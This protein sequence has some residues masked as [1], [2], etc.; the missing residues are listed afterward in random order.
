MVDFL[1]YLQSDGVNAAIG[2]LLSFVVEWWP[3][4]DLLPPR[5]KRLIMLGACLALPLLAALV[6]SAVLHAQPLEIDTFWQAARAGFLAFVA[7]TAAHT[8]KL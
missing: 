4:Y 7:S 1:L 5:A 3:G 8:R 6:G 2:F